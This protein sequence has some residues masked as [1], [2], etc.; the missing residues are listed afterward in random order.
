MKICKWL[1]EKHILITRI[2]Y[3]DVFLN[4]KGSKKEAGHK[5]FQKMKHQAC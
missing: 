2:K 3:G 4:L 5:K 1:L